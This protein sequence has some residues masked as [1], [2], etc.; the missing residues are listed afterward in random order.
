MRSLPLQS[1]TQKLSSSPAHW[2]HLTHLVTRNTM[3]GAHSLPVNTFHYSFCQIRNTTSQRVE[4]SGPNWIWHQV[5]NHSPV[6]F[7][8]LQS[9]AGTPLHA[10]ERNQEDRLQLPFVS[11]KTNHHLPKCTN[12][13]SNS[14]VSYEMTSGI[15]GL[16][17]SMHS[18]S[19][20][21]KY[22]IRSP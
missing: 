3:K 2:A 11:T 18:L 5:L 8:L 13:P 12:G 7:K 6:V 19:L 4:T 21:L 22:D 15:Y 16:L 9:T 10:S 17:H 14:T 20:V 1:L